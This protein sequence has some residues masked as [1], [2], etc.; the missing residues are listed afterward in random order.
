MNT[1]ST[2]TRQMSSAGDQCE[3]FDS[4]SAGKRYSPNRGWSGGRAVKGWVVKTLK[5]F[6]GLEFHLQGLGQSKLSL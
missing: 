6:K 5:N 3:H 4:E 1:A 2:S